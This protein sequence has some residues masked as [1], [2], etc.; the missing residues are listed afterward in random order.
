MYLNFKS[1]KISMK[2]TKETQKI[3]LEKVEEITMSRLPEEMRE[4]YVSII[5][6]FRNKHKMENFLDK[7]DNR[8]TDPDYSI[9]EMKEE[10]EKYE[11]YSK[12][13]PKI[14]EALDAEMVK[15]D[16]AQWEKEKR[17]TFFTRTRDSEIT[18]DG[19]N[20]FKPKRVG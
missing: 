2:E 14:K 18:L 12:E 10:D 9:E 7:V 16:N 3:K 19:K 15:F 5:K 11:R 8:D 6:M 20:Y 17:E 13:L 1:L 4:W